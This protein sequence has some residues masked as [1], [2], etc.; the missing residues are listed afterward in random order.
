MSGRHQARLATPFGMVG[1]ETESGRLAAIDFLPAKTPPLPPRDPFTAEVVRQLT[2]WF[3]DARFVF[4]LPI[5][6]GGTPFQRRVWQALQDIPRGAVL[7]YGELARALHTSA[8]AV[9]QACG[10]NPI[11][12]VIPCHRVV[13]R[14]GPGGFMHQRAGEA[15]AIKDWL[16][17]HERAA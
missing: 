17:R 16:L 1:I 12:V 13:A 14:S 8:R 3:A 15:L 9:G 10:A 2:A 11:P 4:D 7:T 5:E 6:P